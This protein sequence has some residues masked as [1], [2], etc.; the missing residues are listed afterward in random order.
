MSA[1]WIWCLKPRSARFTLCLSRRSYYDIALALNKR[2]LFKSLV[3]RLPAVV[4][5]HLIPCEGS[6]QTG[7]HLINQTQSP[8]M[9]IIRCHW[10]WSCGADKQLTGDMQ[11]GVGPNTWSQYLSSLRD[12]AWNFTRQESDPLHSRLVIDMWRYGEWPRFLQ[13]NDR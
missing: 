3:Q 12:K 7:I 1:Y 9:T 8:H 6:I 11:A 13:T 5:S 10:W 2:H 4:S